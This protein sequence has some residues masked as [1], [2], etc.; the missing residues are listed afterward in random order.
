MAYLP[1]IVGV[2]ALIGLAIF[3]WQRMGPGSGRAFGNRIAAHIGV[4]RNVFW[5]LLDNGVQG[6]SHAMLASLEASRLGLDE[7]SLRLG[8]SLRRGLERLETRFGPQAMVEQARPIVERLAAQ[9][10]PKP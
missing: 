10:G 4:P 2:A 1:M 6:S 3:F 9:S 7:A 5:M 8:P